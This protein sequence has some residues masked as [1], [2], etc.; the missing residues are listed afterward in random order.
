MCI[1]LKKVKII[2]GIELPI[3]LDEIEHAKYFSIMGVATPDSVHIEQ[4]T[5]ASRYLTHINGEEYQI[6]KR[7]FK[8]VELNEKCSID[9]L[10]DKMSESDID[11]SNCRGQGHDNGINVSGKYNGAQ[12]HI[13]HN[14]CI[15]FA[16]WV[17]FA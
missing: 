4:R 2:R 8:F 14:L 13:L 7:F 5:F 17:S 11:Y 1:Y 16:L 10:L 6:Q 15:F 3:S 9:T 12:S